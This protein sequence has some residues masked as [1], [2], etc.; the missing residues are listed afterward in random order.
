MLAIKNSHSNCIRNESPLFPHFIAH[1][2]FTHGLL[3]ELMNDLVHLS[4]INL[5]GAPV[6]KKVSKH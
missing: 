5:A 2:D 3:V 1:R 6:V 4:T